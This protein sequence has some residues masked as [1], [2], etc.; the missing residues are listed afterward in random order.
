VDFDEF[1]H[2][3]ARTANH[4]LSY[5]DR[6]VQAVFGLVGETGEVVDHVKKWRYHGHDLDMKHVCEEL[7]DML[8]YYAEICNALGVSL[9]MIAARNIAKLKA[10]YP[11]GFDAQR[12]IN[13]E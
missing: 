8:F 1:Q 13:R 12:S 3:S 11:A 2:K 9:D 5:E 10:R 7:G 6:V 4:S